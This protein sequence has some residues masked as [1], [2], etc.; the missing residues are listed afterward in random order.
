MISR[1]EP[2]ALSNLYLIGGS[3]I[4][5]ED[6][7]NEALSPLQLQTLVLSELQL[8]K[9]PHS[10]LEMR[11]TLRVLKLCGNKISQ[12]PDSIGQL[13]NLRILCLDHQNPKIKTVPKSFLL[14]KEL[15]VSVKMCY[16]IIL[17]SKLLRSNLTRSSVS[18]VTDWK[19][20]IGCLS[21]KTCKNW[22]WIAI[23]FSAFPPRLH[24]S[25]ASFHLTSPTIASN[26]FH[27]AMLTSS[28]DWGISSSS[29]FHWDL[30]MRVTT[31]PP[32][33]TTWNCKS[34]SQVCL[35]T[36]Q[37]PRTSS[38]GWS[39]VQILA[40][41][42]LFPPWKKRK[43]FAG[44]RIFVFLFQVGLSKNVSINV[45]SHRNANLL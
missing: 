9:V 28:K 32:S 4:T 17:N 22:D 7:L 24:L 16:E 34:F 10:I 39:G 29:T 26:S 38:W 40:R 33:S 14:L 8:T 1:L 19:R 36:Q 43:E 11:L 44:W 25:S 23:K 45:I 6:N 13:V 20:W 31:S 21:S 2:K 35:P 30:T 41:S 5:D 12:I 15:Q 18:A 37:P 3:A 27:P 42:H